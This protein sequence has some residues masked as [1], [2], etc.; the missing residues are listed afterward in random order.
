MEFS[1]ISKA[2]RRKNLKK[3]NVRKFLNKIPQEIREYLEE[4]FLQDGPMDETKKN[5]VINY[6]LKT[7]AIARAINKDRGG[8]EIFYY[9]Y[10]KLSNGHLDEYYLV[11]GSGNQIYRRLQVMVEKI[12]VI[13]RKY[14]P[15]GAVLVNN[16]ASGQGYDMIYALRDNEDLRTRVHVNNIDP[17]ERALQQGWEKIIEYG[18]E[19]NFSLFN[20]TFKSYSGSKSELCIVSGVFCPMSTRLSR[21]MLHEIIV[22]N[23]IKERA[24]LLYNATTYE[25]LLQESFTD[26]T[27]R[28]LNWNMGFKTLVDIRYI[29]EDLFEIKEEFADT[30]DEERIMGFNHMVVAQKK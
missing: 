2:M 12:P 14:F 27:M 8:A 21:K 15:I 3:T 24:F 13:I 11:S 18:L 16:V 29:C 10:N 25:M 22:P 1:N 7:S 26:Y 5:V 9:L 19:N 6:F 4:G 28:L 30:D 20:D 17:N 23:F